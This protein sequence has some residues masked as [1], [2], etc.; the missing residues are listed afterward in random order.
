MGVKDADAGD[1][2]VV[3]DGD[4]HVDVVGE[5]ADD[6]LHHDAFLAAVDAG[7]VAVGAGVFLLGVLAAAGDHVAEYLVQLGLLVG[8]GGTGK[9]GGG[10]EEHQSGDEDDSDGDKELFHGVIH[11][12]APP[13]TTP[14]RLMGNALSNAQAQAFMMRMA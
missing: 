8:G 6:H 2:A 12:P 4:E 13:F 9:A 10:R 3:A 7:D 11:F 14:K 1:G 5:A